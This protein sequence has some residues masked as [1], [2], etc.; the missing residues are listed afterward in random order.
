MQMNF[1]VLRPLYL[2]ISSFEEWRDW[3][4]SYNYRQAKNVH[5]H[6]QVS[7]FSRNKGFSVQNDASSACL[8]RIILWITS[9][10]PY[11]GQGL[12]CGKGEIALAI[13]LTSG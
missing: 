1:H 2:S 6:N 3:S 11:Y 13:P 4:G 10:L 9:S 8:A 5:L 12:C 7:T